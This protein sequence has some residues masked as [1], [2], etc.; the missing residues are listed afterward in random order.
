MSHDRKLNQYPSVVV[1]LPARL[2]EKFKLGY[3]QEQ[4]ML[5]LFNIWFLFIERQYLPLDQMVTDLYGT[6]YLIAQRRFWACWSWCKYHQLQGRWMY[7]ATQ[8]ARRS[9]LP[10]RRHKRFK[11]FHQKKKKKWALN[12]IL[13]RQSLLLYAVYLSFLH[14]PVTLFGLVPFPALL[15]AY[16]LSTTSL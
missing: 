1:L 9:D 2:C 15:S 16:D 12:K 5:S 3:Q 14:L 8:T 6:I 10:K 11:A 7:C 4:S 13:C